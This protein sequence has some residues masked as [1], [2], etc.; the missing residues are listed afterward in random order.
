MQFHDAKKYPDSSSLGSGTWPGRIVI[1]KERA[2]KGKGRERP[3]AG[4]LLRLLRQVRNGAG[5]G[6]QLGLALSTAL[7]L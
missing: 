2:E 7:L 3:V 4:L 1:E 6:A 5:P